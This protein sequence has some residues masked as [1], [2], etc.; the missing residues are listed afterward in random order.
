MLRTFSYK[1]ANEEM[2][3]IVYWICGLCTG[4]VRRNAIHLLL[5]LLEINGEL[6]GVLRYGNLNLDAKILHSLC[7]WGNGKVKTK[8]AKSR[9]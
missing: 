2:N 3:M 9:L 6:C 5:S 1:T 4:S 8:K 7:V